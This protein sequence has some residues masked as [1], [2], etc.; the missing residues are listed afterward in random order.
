LGEVI[1]SFTYES[2]QRT[3]VRD[4]RGNVQTHLYDQQ[5]A[6]AGLEYTENGQ[7]R[8]PGS[9]TLVQTTDHCPFVTPMALSPNCTGALRLQPATYHYSYNNM[10]RRTK[11]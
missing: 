8:T 6:F 3:A 1:A 2:P 10:I 5:G 9:I 11:R 7:L 4:G